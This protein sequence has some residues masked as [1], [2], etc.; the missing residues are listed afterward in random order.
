MN[1]PPSG[2]ASTSFLARAYVVVSFLA[3]APSLRVWLQSPMEI[4]RW[5]FDYFVGLFG[6]APTPEWLRYTMAGC[7]AF[8]LCLLLGGLLFWAI[9]A[10]LESEDE[11]SDGR[12]VREATWLLVTVFLAGV[13]FLNVDVFFYIGK[14][15][16]ESGYGLSP[17]SAAMTGVPSWETEGMFRNVYWGFRSHVDSNYGPF[18]FK[19]AA[20]L[21]WLSGGSEKAALALFKV[22][23]L[24]LH[25]LAGAIVAR[26]VPPE[27]RRFTFFVYVL[28]PV[29]LYSFVTAAHNDVLMN[30]L[31][32]A[33]LLA[34]RRGR[35]LGAGLALGM[36]AAVKY[37][38]LAFLPFFVATLFPWTR[39]Q[40]RERGLGPLLRLVLGFTAAFVAAHALYP[41]GFHSLLVAAEGG[42]GSIR[43]SLRHVA[44][45]VHLLV[46]P[47]D[48]AAFLRVTNLLF[49]LAYGV[50]SVRFVLARR[51]ERK[52]FGLEEAATISV[53]A[54]FLLANSSNHEWYLSWILGFA[55]AAPDR[56]FSAFAV[57]I[58]ALYMALVVYTVNSPT[59]VVWVTNTVQYF[60]ILGCAAPL[61]WRLA[62]RPA[63]GDERD[64]APN[65]THP[66]ASPQAFRDDPL[67]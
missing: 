27:R 26:L 60:V 65:G 66:A 44:F 37:V 5:E 38:P 42:S 2:R 57:R 16:L 53:L 6:D 43:S 55:L 62:R 11:V 8:S 49:V 54:Y 19:V 63:D 28:N 23:S 18:F 30:A 32:L 24:G 46:V 29:S 33:G 35:P 41:E 4:T 56:A 14:G 15:W 47:I 61:L 67:P 7:F 22:V 21:T 9:A 64:D 17:Y 51:A 34:F 25:L 59:A 50:I 48:A 39:E 31:V 13:P 20:A 58:S 36:A 40:L 10:R 52:G 12:T 1:P 45:L 3:V